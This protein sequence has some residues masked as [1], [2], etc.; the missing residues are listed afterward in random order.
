MEFA[1]VAGLGGDEVLEHPPR[2]FEFCIPEWGACRGHTR[3]TIVGF[4]VKGARAQGSSTAQGLV[5]LAQHAT[6]LEHQA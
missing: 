5:W 1:P 3:P 2:G 6:G 4:L